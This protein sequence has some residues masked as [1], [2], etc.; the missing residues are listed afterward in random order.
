MRVKKKLLSI[1]RVSL[2]NPN[3]DTVLKGK[4][5]VKKPKIVSNISKRIICFVCA[6]EIKMKLSFQNDQ[7]DESIFFK[8]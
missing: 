3:K 6:A 2:K 5:Q 4:C 1:F 8:V 7:S